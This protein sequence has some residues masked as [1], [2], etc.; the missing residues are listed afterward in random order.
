MYVRASFCV[1][2]VGMIVSSSG[3]ALGLNAGVG[4]SVCARRFPSAATNANTNT[5]NVFV[6]ITPRP[7]RIKSD[8][9][10]HR[11]PKHFVQNSWQRLDHFAKALGVRTRPRVA[12]NLALFNKCDDI[13]TGFAPKSMPLQKSVHFF[14]QLSANPFSRSNLLNTCFPETI[15][16]PK[17]PQ[18]Q[19][20][21]VL[22]YTRAIIENALFDAFFH[23]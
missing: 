12:L 9:E 8:A 1:S 14:G 15:H 19:I 23:E 21:P 7:E 2:N 20:L 16:R 6:I 11:T 17:S 3:E 22:A 13:S 4:I 10:T 18:Q 5:A